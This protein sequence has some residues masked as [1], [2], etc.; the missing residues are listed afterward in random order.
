MQFCLEELE[1]GGHKIGGEREM[2]VGYGYYHSL[3]VDRFS[4]G[5]MPIAILT[6]VMIRG[7][8]WSRN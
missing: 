3:S 7:V 4:W 1:A 2:S 6:T 8:C 5:S